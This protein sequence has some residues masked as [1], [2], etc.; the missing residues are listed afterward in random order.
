MHDKKVK[1][2]IEV[3]NAENKP[4]YIVDHEDGSY[5]LCLCFLYTDG[6]YCQ[7]GISV[8]AVRVGPVSYGHSCG[9][10]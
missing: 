1:E 2:R 6:D 10:V 4:F 3:F 7:D 8:Y 5:S 9:C